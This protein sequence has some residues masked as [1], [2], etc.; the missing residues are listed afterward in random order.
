[1]RDILMILFL[2]RREIVYT[3]IIGLTVYWLFGYES[4]WLSIDVELADH[5]ICP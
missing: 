2:N 5:E 3:K 1:M 4:I